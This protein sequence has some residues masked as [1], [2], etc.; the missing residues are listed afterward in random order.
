MMNALAS[1]VLLGLVQAN[2]KDSVA[3]QSS[4]YPTI[5]LAYTPSSPLIVAVSAD[6]AQF[7]AVIVSKIRSL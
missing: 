5:S 3:K 4:S 6:V 2:R 7:S 1:Q